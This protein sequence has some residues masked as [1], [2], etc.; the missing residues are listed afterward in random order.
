MAEMQL[1]LLV[2]AV[3]AMRWGDV[4]GLRDGT[5]EIARDEL[6][7]HLLAADPRLVGVDL[8][9]VAPGESCR[10]APVFDVVEPRAKLGA[11]VDFPG[12]LGA[13]SGAGEGQTVVLR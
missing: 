12:V 5:L 7:R 10:L 6:T 13:A 4:T 9:L 11:G 3:R 8:E 2:H 1:E